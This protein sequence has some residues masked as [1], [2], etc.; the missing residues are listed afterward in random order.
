VVKKT[1]FIVLF[2]VTTTLIFAYLQF[3]R[4]VNEEVKTLYSETIR[5]DEVITDNMLQDLPPPVQRYMRYSGVVGKPWINTVNLKQIGQMKTG[6]QGKWFPIVAEEYYS[7]NPPSF[8]W[9]VWSPKKWLPII[10]GRDSYQDGKGQLLIKLLSLFSV[11]DSKGEELD[12]GAMM[13]YLNEMMWFPTA[14]LGK[15]I[16]WKA[17]DENSAEVTFTVKDKSVNAIM[18]FNSEGKLINFVAKRYMSKGTGFS[19]ET[20]ET[21]ILGY[22]EVNGFNLPTKGS[23]VWKLEDGDYKYI[24]ISVNKVEYN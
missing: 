12:Q 10:H 24:Y 4:L 11:A 3:D 8:I 20:W 1:I 13:R 9:R 19:L 23:A 7:T 2:L 18:Y 16:S 22:S 15:N 5:R 6:P 14:F 17:I 21:P